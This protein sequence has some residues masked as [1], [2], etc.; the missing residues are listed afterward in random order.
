MQTSGESWQDF[1]AMTL[2]LSATKRYSKRSP[3][4]V[5]DLCLDLC[6]LEKVNKQPSSNGSTIT[7]CP[8]LI[9]VDTPSHIKRLCSVSVL[10]ISK[11]NSYRKVRIAYI[12]SHA[13]LRSVCRR[14]HWRPRKPCQHLS[15]LALSILKYLSASQVQMLNW[16]LPS[17]T[18]IAFKW[19]SLLTPIILRNITSSHRFGFWFVLLIKAARWIIYAAH[20]WNEDG[21]L[22]VFSLQN[23]TTSSRASI[24][25]LWSAL[26]YSIFRKA[27]LIKKCLETRSTFLMLSHL[28]MWLIRNVYASI[29]V[30]CDSV[31]RNKTFLRFREYLD[32]KK[33]ADV[34]TNL[35]ACKA[36]EYPIKSGLYSTLCMATDRTIKR[37]WIL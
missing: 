18:G 8:S 36:S 6:T 22:D 34:L 35:N 10:P 27:K 33:S 11:R 31:I 29:T 20:Q 17:R 24:G 3:E 16:S 9:T 37:N 2:Y 7:I 1:K 5:G 25:G 21:L 32:R 14:P 12:T 19:R 15:M 4:I 30:S 28:S 13:T 26:Y 23:R